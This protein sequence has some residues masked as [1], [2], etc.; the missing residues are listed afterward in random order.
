MALITINNAQTIEISIDGSRKRTTY[1]SLLKNPP[2]QLHSFLEH[3]LKARLRAVPVLHD[4][5]S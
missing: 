4:E 3:L 1:V 2:K 5:R